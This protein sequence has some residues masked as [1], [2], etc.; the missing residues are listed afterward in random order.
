MKN[1]FSDSYTIVLPFSVNLVMEK[2]AKHSMRGT[3]RVK[4]YCD[5]FVLSP[6]SE[7]EV[8]ECFNMCKA[9]ME[10]RGLKVNNGKM[11]ILVSGKECYSAVTVN[12]LVKS[13]FVKFVVNSTSNA[14]S[15]RIVHMPSILYVEHIYKQEMSKRCRRSILCQA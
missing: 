3:L 13:V 5:D 11:K 2:T 15:D 12:T 6:E 10:R 4:L 14:L 1:Q 7:M 9:A 8:V